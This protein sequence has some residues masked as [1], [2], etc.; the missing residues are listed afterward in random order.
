[1]E[2]GTAEAHRLSELEAD[3]FTGYYLTH[4]RGGTYNWK[5]VAEFFELF[6]NIGDCSFES[7]G[8]HGTP[9][10]RLAAARLGSILAEETFPKGH[11]LEPEQVH[12][13]F[14]LAYEDIIENSISS[15]EALASLGSAQLKGIYKAILEHE[16]ELKQILKRK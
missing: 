10:Q 13:L 11:I 1:M 16:H 14:L 3:F 7:S 4:K 12:E 2:Q 5:R 9:N 8:H 15:K 6:Y